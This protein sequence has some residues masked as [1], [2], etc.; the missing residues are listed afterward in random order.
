MAISDLFIYWFNLF[1]WFAAEN[2]LH[3]CSALA[4][5]ENNFEADRSIIF[6]TNKINRSTKW[7]IVDKSTRKVFQMYC[8]KLLLRINSYIEI[9]S[10]S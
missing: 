3:S 4:G 6:S 2:I 5:A 1:D 8:H 10:I 7:K 9:K